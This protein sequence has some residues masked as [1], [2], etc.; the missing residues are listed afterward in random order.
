MT[1]DAVND[2]PTLKLADIGVAMGIAGTET[3]ISE[4]L[5]Q[6]LVKE[7]ASLVTMP[8]WVNPWLLLAMAVSFGLHF[9]ILYGPSF[10][11]AFGIVPLSFN[12]WL[13]ILIVAFPVI[14]IDEALKLAR[15]AL[16]VSVT[17]R[18]AKAV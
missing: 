8:P 18:K 16:G 5:L 4:Q 10:A 2:A 15:C 1:G 13:L 9:F 17:P 6:Q 11:S 14:I 7:D 12:E 3:T